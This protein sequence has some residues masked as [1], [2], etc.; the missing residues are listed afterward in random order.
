MNDNLPKFSEKMNED[1][2]TWIFKMEANMDLNGIHGEQR[3]LAVAQYV[4]GHAL[5]VYMKYKN[6][7]TSN[8]KIVTWTDR[9]RDN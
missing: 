3:V 2:N 7:A 9:S 8:G 6:N 5:H 4:T 1:I